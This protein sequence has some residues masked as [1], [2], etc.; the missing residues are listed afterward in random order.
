MKEDAAA[1]NLP[2]V[3]RGKWAS[4]SAEEVQAAKD[5]GLDY[6][7]R[8]RVPKAR[9]RLCQSSRCAI[10]GLRRSGITDAWP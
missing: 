5:A 10:Y 4:A 6:T 3:Y 1:K 9:L 8:F 2:P 7:Y